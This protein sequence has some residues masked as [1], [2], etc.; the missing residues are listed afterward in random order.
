MLREQ[1][2]RRHIQFIGEEAN[3][4]EESIA[5]NLCHEEG[6]SYGNIEMT[7]EE[8]ALRQIPPGHADD[9]SV[10][11]DEKARGNRERR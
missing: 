3:H 11:D 6:C 4:E 2:R 5:R 9:P 1:I 10:P 8:R 7:P